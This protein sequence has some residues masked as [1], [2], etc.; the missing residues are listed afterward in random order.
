M[1]EHRRDVMVIQMAEGT[2]NN[3]FR[4]WVHP[5]IVGSGQRFVREGNGLRLLDRQ[6]FDADVVVLTYQPT[7]S[8]NDLSMTELGLAMLG[9]SGWPEA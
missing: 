9:V 5:V 8:E 4:R 3:E 7:L 6:A 2:M 1:G